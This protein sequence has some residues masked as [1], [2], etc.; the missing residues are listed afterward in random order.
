MAASQSKNSISC[1]GREL[2]SLYYPYQGFRKWCLLAY[3]VGGL[4]VGFFGGFQKGLTT[5]TNQQSTWLEWT[6]YNQEWH[7]SVLWTIH[8]AATRRKSLNDSL[9]IQFM[10][11]WVSTIIYYLQPSSSTEPTSFIDVPSV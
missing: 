4:M 2:P 1:G 8:V 6:A 9:A 5:S 7:Y 11:W 10:I 3:G